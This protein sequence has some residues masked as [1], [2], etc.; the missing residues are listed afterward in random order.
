MAL[1]GLLLVLSPYLVFQ[2]INP[3]ARLLTFGNPITLK[4]PKPISSTVSPTLGCP[5]GS[6]GCKQTTVKTLFGTLRKLTNIYTC[7]VS[8][9]QFAEAKCLS[10]KPPKQLHTDPGVPPYTPS[11]VCLKKDG[12]VDKNG[13][14]W[15]SLLPSTKYTCLHNESPAI[16]C[17]FYT[18]GSTK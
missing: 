14:T 2:I 12:T 11:A 5:G 6:A 13:R 8:N 7:K 10:N 4:Q 9:C 15:T 1:A 16:K 18:S 17:T 3:R